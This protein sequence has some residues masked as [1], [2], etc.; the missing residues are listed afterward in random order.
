MTTGPISDLLPESFRAWFAR[1]GWQAHDHQLAMLRAAQAGRSALLI[2]PTGGGKTLAGFLPSLVELADGGYDGLHTLYVSPLKA[3][4]V[5]IHRNLEVPVAEMELPIRIE[6]RTGDTPQSKRLRQRTKPPQMLLTTPESLALLLSY[7]DA[8]QMFAGLKCVVLDELHAIAGTK[9]G[10]LLALGLARLSS[11]APGCRRVGLSATVAHRDPLIAYLSTEGRADAGDVALVAGGEAAKPEVKILLPRGRMPWSGHMAVFALPEVYEA[12][13]A[14]KTAIVFVNTRAQAEIVFQELWRLNDD[15][16]PIGLH[17]GS[18]AVEQRRKV[19]AAMAR[20][21]LRAVVATSSLDLG[22]DWAAVD[23]VVQIGAPKG[24]SR[25]LQRIGRANHRLDTPSRALLVPANRFEVLECRAALDGIRAMELDG[26]P[27]RPGG[28]DVLAQHIVGTACAGPFQADALYAEIA[29]AA[30]YAGLDRQTFDD[31]LEFCATGGYALRSYERYR[32]LIGDGPKGSGGGWRLSHPS[33]LRR[34]RMNVGTIVEAVTL[35]VRLNRG[36]VLG[37]VEEYFV[38]GLEPGDTFLF[39][40]RLLRFDG[41][42]E[43]M[44]QASPATGDAPKI[45]AYAGGRL[46]LST[47]LADRVRGLLQDDAN[48]PTL[49]APVEE[50]LRMQQL[51]SIM[52]RRDGLLVESFPR[53][54]KEFLV[55]YC[56]EG[57][58]AHQTL[59]M[60][61]T[62]RMER[63]GFGP[64][65]FVASDYVLAVWSVTPVPAA[66]MDDLFAE[67]LLGDD[68]EEWMDESSM[69]RRTF[70]NVAVIAGLIEKRSPGQEKTGRQVTFSTDLIYDVLRKHEPSHVLLRATRADAAGG[71]TDISRLSAML[72]RIRGRITHRRLD[73]I[74][75]L[76]VPVMLEIGREQVYGAGLDDLLDEAAEALIDDATRLPPQ[77]SLPL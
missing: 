35:K 70:R 67:D 13:K 42:R 53:G 6:T 4:A 34:Y 40:G 12:V 19:E 77:A 30:P 20:G 57:R 22:I 43:T 23:L 11:L 2:A 65:G 63:M 51:R 8:P 33:H 32:R 28:L 58:N 72:G 59:G 45:P 10:D 69:L 56:F 5:D 68:L 46:P 54:G 18:L 7:P 44:V 75:P 48:W 71:L 50:W 41:L 3:L 76:A 1:R 55:A 24:V 60:L 9:R 29:S 64:L 49:P 52:P 73:R 26:D 27:P 74:S 37:E 31:V 47:S 16:L 17:H 66:A 61:L 36:P 15:N 39:A 21:A 38:M 62:R 14:A 25:L